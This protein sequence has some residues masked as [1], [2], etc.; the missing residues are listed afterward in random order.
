MNEQEHRIFMRIW[1][2]RE[3]KQIIFCVFAVGVVL[4]ALA[5][6]LIS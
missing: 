5:G 2:S 4:G 3:F 6:Y 1:N